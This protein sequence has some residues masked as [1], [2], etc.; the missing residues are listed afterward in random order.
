MDAHQVVVRSMFCSK[1]LLSV[2]QTHRFRVDNQYAAEKR[3]AQVC[4][5][6]LPAYPKLTIFQILR[7][8]PDI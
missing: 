6:G 3:E 4:G 1:V 7:A 5:N 8:V 2:T